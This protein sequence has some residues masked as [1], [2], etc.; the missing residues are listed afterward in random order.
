MKII[1]IGK[2][3]VT[4]VREMPSEKVVPMIFTKADTTLLEDNKDL[5]LPTFSREVWYEAELAFRIGKTCKNAE[6]QNALDFIDAVT[7]SNDLTA[8]DVLVASKAL[9]GP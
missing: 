8:K 6:L 1:A 5:V 3:Y 2:N 9:Q 4:D 7:L